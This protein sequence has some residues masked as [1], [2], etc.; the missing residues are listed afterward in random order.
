MIGLLAHPLSHALLAQAQNPPPGGGSGTGGWSYAIA[1]GLLAAAVALFF[2]EVFIPSGGLLG[3]GAIICML[4][5]VV[6]CFRIDTTL[7][8]ISAILALIGI[9]IALGIA[10]RI[11]PETPVLRMLALKA[12]Q[13]PVVRSSRLR[14][15]LMR[16]QSDPDMADDSDEPAVPAGEDSLIGAAGEAITDLRPV[17]TCILDGRREECLSVGGVIERGTPV[18]V[19]SHDGMQIKVRPR[20]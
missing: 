6:A 7:G 11:A 16:E 2:L 14:H 5:G 17:G 20:D 15:A 9:P 3:I 8:M 1:A 4:S 10:I 12:S 19:V 13:T 18:E